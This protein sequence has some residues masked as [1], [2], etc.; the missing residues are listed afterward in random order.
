MIRR[1]HLSRRLTAALVLLAAVAVIVAIVLITQ[2]SSSPSPASASSPASGATAV[3]RRNLVS[4]D[5]ESGTLSYA[6]P[7]SVYNRLSGTI[8]WLPSVG[9]TIE[10]G[11]ALFKVDNEP[12]VLMNGTTPAYRDLNASDGAGPDILELNRD[13]VAMGYDSEGIVVDDDWQAA[14]SAAVEVFQESLG[15]SPTGDLT[16]GQAVFLPGAQVVSSITATLGDAGGGSSSAATDLTVGTTAPEFVSLQT[17]PQRKPHGSRRRNPTTSKLTELEALIAL[18]KAEIAE[19]KGSSHGGSPSHGG[20]N[21]SSSGSPSKS[22]NSGNPSSS[23]ASSSSGGGSPS[24]SGS[25]SPSSG[26]GG[27]AT[28][29]M[30]TSSTQLVATVDLDASKQ[31]EA[32]VGEKVTVE[33]PAGNT[34]NGRITAVSPVAQSSSGNGNGNGNGSGNGNGNGNGG[35]GGNGNG[36]SG[37]TVP[38]TITLSGHQ[39]GAGLDQAAVSVNFVQSEANNVMS[40]PVTALL[41][42]AGGGYAVQDAAAPH[43]VI[44]VNTGLFA[45]GYVQISGAGIYP[46]LEVTDSQG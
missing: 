35:G 33:M 30:Q 17:K 4:T 38:V 36:S 42:V 12:V 15:E 37:A 27:A 41:A 24:S 13:L 23:S 1:H 46:G 6:N 28:E 40:V 11:E 19:L 18:L 32:K 29:V 7:Q 21:P 16:L 43:K 5:T 14:T 25:G 3:Q 22:S 2:A 26:G 39:R 8:T 20:S 44:P 34:V 45:A 9:Q 31:S 10:P